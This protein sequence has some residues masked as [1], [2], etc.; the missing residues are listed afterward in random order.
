M[1]PGE[2]LIPAMSYRTSRTTAQQ[3]LRRLQDLQHLFQRL[4]TA[5]LPQPIIV[6][7]RTMTRV[8]HCL[9]QQQ[10]DQKAKM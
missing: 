4:S 7:S 3:E 10:Y 2:G 9:Q 6:C 8:I 1:P 5:H